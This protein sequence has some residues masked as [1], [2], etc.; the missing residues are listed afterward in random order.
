MITLYLLPY[1]THNCCFGI[2]NLSLLGKTLWD[3]QQITDESCVNL[4][5]SLVKS[6]IYYDQLFI[7]H[8]ALLMHLCDGWLVFIVYPTYLSI[9]V[10][11]LLI[12]LQI[13]ADRLAITWIYFSL[14][15]MLF[16][17]FFIIVTCSSNFPL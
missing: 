17:N 10:F 14:I 3:Y 6:K 5:T 8:K 1:H 15:S 13:L 16:L 11:P 12:T 9:Y 7:L 4:E 2:F